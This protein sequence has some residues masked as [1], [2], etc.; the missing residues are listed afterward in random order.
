MQADRIDQGPLDYV[1]EVIAGA[2]LLVVIFSTCWGVVTRYITE[3][4]AAWTGEVA[5]IG[6]AWLVFVGAAAG[7]K[8][9]AHISI[10]MLVVKLPGPLRRAVMLA[11]DALVLA[12]LATLLVLSVQFSIDSW[13]DPT[14]V[15]RLPRTVT[16]SSVV[17]G[18]LCMLVRFARAAWRRWRGHSAAWL[19]MAAPAGAEL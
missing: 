14:S 3:Q 8:Y 17:V 10:D 4:P 6:F 11:A 1:E 16:Y 15:L 5:G 13:G 9:G 2:A 7:V 19:T 12:F 18:S